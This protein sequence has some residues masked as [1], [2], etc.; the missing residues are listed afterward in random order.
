MF[1]FSGFQK[2]PAILEKS[3]LG[4][5]KRLLFGKHSKISYSQCGEDIIIAGVLAALGI[6]RPTY[7][8]IG[9]FNPVYLSNTYF[10]YQ[11]GSNGVCIEPNR[12]LCK[13][14]QRK[15]PKDICINMGIGLSA[16]AEAP[17]YIMNEA[18]LSTFSK[19][20]A[21]RMCSYGNLSIEKVITIPLITLVEVIEKYL[22]GCP[23]F[24]SLDVEGLDLEILKSFDFAK[25]RPE[26][27][28][29]ETITYTEDKSE[30]KIVPTIE[31]MQSNGYF[32][33]ADTYIN[34]IFVDRAAWAARP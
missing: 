31:F 21:E 32:V 7:I 34:T 30:K 9:A 17:F 25:Y 22:K 1:S 8:D 16:A 5:I 26:I 6:K 20:E 23:N 27:F 15:R 29:V 13:N 33:Y 4:A 24:I 10:F 2:N 3:P 19:E 28:C 11:K 14:I 12:V 18:T